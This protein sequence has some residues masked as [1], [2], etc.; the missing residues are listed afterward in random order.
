MTV[1]RG[2]PDVVRVT[3]D[4]VLTTGDAVGSAVIAFGPPDQPWRHLIV[5]VG[6][7]L[8]YLPLVT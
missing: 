7:L 2:G 1:L 3:Q 4:G 8:I 5:Y 6:R